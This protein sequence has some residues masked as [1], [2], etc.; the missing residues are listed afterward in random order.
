MV[1]DPLSFRFQ[2]WTLATARIAKICGLYIWERAGPKDPRYGMRIEGSGFLWSFWDLP[3]PR[4]WTLPIL[5]GA[6][7]LSNKMISSFE[8]F[9][10]EKLVLRLRVRHT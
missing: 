3:L 2:D 10:K 5:R 8:M 7:R 9:L 1:F 6:V 4:L